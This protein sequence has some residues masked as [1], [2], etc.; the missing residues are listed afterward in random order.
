M[1]C[2]SDEI[3][4]EPIIR[5]V[6]THKQDRPTSSRRKK[7]KR[8]LVVQKLAWYTENS[9]DRVVW[10]KEAQV[11]D[12]KSQSTWDKLYDDNFFV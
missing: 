5:D 2:N 1:S 3:I 10:G 8:T 4:R 9:I 12:S 11:W 6:E 7:T